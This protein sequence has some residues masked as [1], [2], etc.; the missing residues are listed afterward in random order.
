VKLTKAPALVAALSLSA[1]VALTS[2]T[3]AQAA[4]AGSPSAR[5]TASAVTAPAAA[6]PL[7]AATSDAAQQLL[8]RLTAKLP[9]D[10]KD[11]Q[12]A[13]F[14]RLGIERSPVR[15]VVDARV[16]EAINPGD[17]VCGPTKLDAYVDSILSDVDM[18]TLLVLAFLGVLDFPTYEAIYYG[19]PKDPGF[20]LTPASASVL[21]SSFGYAQ[22]FW[23]VKLDDVQLMAMHGAMLTDVDR[24]ARIVALLYGTSPSD[25]VDT[26]REIVKLVRTGAGLDRGRN[27]IFTLNAFA[28]SAQGETDPVVSRLPDKLVFGDGILDALRALGLKQVG[29]KAVM[30]H[31]MAHH[32]QYEDNLFQ[33]ELTG[34]EATR[35][36]ELMADSF[37]AYFATHKKGLGLNANQLLLVQD[38]FYDVGDCQFASNGHHGTP[39][40][41]RAAASWGV[42]TAATGDQVKVLPSLRLAARFDRIL[43]K[44]V[45]PDVPTTPNAWRQ[46]AKDAA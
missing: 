19:S 5:A 15:D 40:Q 36:T 9:A 42:A 10:W 13:T 41:R 18:N 21:S 46:V 20:A 38:T 11:R 17:Y 3:A 28:F 22:R 30:G 43:P 24:V 16:A 7:P 29:P 2:T 45:A 26:A 35:R 23:D 27:P 34:P 32:V 31:E 37:G 39:N 33:S 1:S 4:N 25:S 14:A 12:A 6:S 8:A 44:L